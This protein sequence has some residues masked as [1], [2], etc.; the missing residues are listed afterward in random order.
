MLKTKSLKDLIIINDKKFNLEYPHKVYKHSDILRYKNKPIEKFYKLSIDDELLLSHLWLNIDYN[1]LE[2]FFYYHAGNIYKFKDTTINYY[3][4]KSKKCFQGSL[5]RQYIIY[6]LLFQHGNKK[7]QFFYYKKINKLLK[8]LINNK[9]NSNNNDILNYKFIMNLIAR[10]ILLEIKFNKKN[11]DISI[12]G[13]W[14]D[15]SNRYSQVHNFYF[16]MLD[17]YKFCFQKFNNDIKNLL[18]NKLNNIENVIV[19]FIQNNNFN[20]IDNLYFKLANTYHY[21]KDEN[22]AQSYYKKEIDTIINYCNSISNKDMSL[23]IFITKAIEI[24]VQNILNGS[25]RLEELKSLSSNLTHYINKTLKPISNDTNIEKAF[26]KYYDLIK[27]DLTKNIHNEKDIITY[28]FLDFT[29]FSFIKSDILKQIDKQKDNSFPIRHLFPKIHSSHYGRISIEDGFDFNNPESLKRLLYKEHFT[30]FISINNQILFN[31]D[32]DSNWVLK[33]KD[34]IFMYIENIKIIESEYK[35]QTIK[36]ISYFIENEYMLFCHLSLPIIEYIL[37]NY[38]A[39]ISGDIYSIKNIKT[40]QY[41]T[42]NELLITIQEHENN[43]IDNGIIDYFKFILVEPDFLNFRNVILH[44]FM[45]ENGFNKWNS[46][47]ILTILF[48]LISYFK[49]DEDII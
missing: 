23:S 46:M 42:L 35:N 40:T 22:K 29:H 19:D 37:R 1:N 45:P 33:S 48:Y 6:E 5:D 47:Y 8:Q 44:G 31:L 24:S 15:K 28:L 11:I 4:E 17:F 12:I 18:L 14:I 16:F 9:L 3:K 13:E 2:N 7:E 41:K 32:Y 25:Y 27:N 30:Q 38:L 39:K 20:I 21:A 43:Y 36:A 10:Y 34:I 26:I 49:N